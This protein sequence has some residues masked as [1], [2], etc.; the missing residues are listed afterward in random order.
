MVKEPS[1]A[2]MNPGCITCSQLICEGVI[3]HLGKGAQKTCDSLR[4]E[5]EPKQFLGSRTD[6]VSI[7]G[8]LFADTRSFYLPKNL[9]TYPPSY[10]SI[11]LSAT[12]NSNQVG[13][14]HNS[15]IHRLFGCHGFIS[16]SYGGSA[17]RF[18]GSQGILLHPLGGMSS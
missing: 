6:V 11:Y 16:R 7:A 15:G 4:L 14:L 8:H 12:S 13:T 5:D 1:F 18:H 2:C 9:P 17:T 10:L 3:D